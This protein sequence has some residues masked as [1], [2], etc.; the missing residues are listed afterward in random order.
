MEKEYCVYV[1]TNK[2]N[3]KRYVGITC[4][5]PEYRWANGKG[6]KENRHFDSAIKKYGWDSFD[7]DVI[8][9]GLTKKQA[10]LWEAVLI[11]Q[12]DTT[13]PTK[14]YNIALGGVGPNSVSTVTR[15][16]MSDQTTRFFENHPE[17]REHLAELGRRQF[18]TYESKQ[19]VSERMK[20]MFAE[21]PE[22]KTT[23]AIRQYDLNG[24][25]IRD[26]ESAVLAEK[27]GGYDRKKISSCLTGHQKSA[28]GYL[29][30]YANKSEP[31]KIE[32][33]PQKQ[34][35]P[36]KQRK[37]KRYIGVEQYDRKG[38]W[39][40][41]FDSVLE[42][43]QVAGVNHSCIIR[44]CRGRG[45]TAGGYQWRYSV[46]KTIQLGKKSKWQRFRVAQ[47]SM[48][49]QLVEIYESVTDAEKAL[50]LNHPSKISYVCNGQRK[51][52]NGYIWKYIDKDIQDII[53]PYQNAC[54]K[55]VCQYDK[56]GNIINVYKSAT[57]AEN[58]TGIKRKNIYRV[59]RGERMSTGGYI[60]RYEDELQNKT[61]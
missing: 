29:W 46:D 37:Y 13:N 52:C 3:G 6:Y 55:R 2:V 49:G 56:G 27:G 51:S 53:S 20:K 35:K 19:A 24:N 42:A 60:W 48:D 9:T 45:H 54:E 36:K 15:K 50:G 7:H 26:W 47:Y 23:K 17:A 11:A 1:H 4:Q 18:S 5:K 39:I 30:R 22:K 58:K 33:I 16:K 44:C 21:H 38:N 40:R 8:M 61:I 10:C 32:G 57:D 41:S 31:T 12:W 28:C 14:G 59:C 34:K 43:T 25:Y